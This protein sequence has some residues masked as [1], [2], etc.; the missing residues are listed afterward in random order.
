[1]IFESKDKSFYTEIV[2][3]WSWYN[4]IFP[5][6]IFFSSF[7]KGNIFFFFFFTHNMYYE[8]QKLIYLKYH[9]KTSIRHFLLKKNVYKHIY[10]N[11]IN[12]KTNKYFARNV[13]NLKSNYP[14]MILIFLICYGLKN[15]RENSLE[16]M[17]RV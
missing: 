6:T 3:E 12:F 13:Q 10:K 5:I 9:L 2:S 14:V 4:S 11:I 7:S 15:M 1:M 17:F 8:K 16:T